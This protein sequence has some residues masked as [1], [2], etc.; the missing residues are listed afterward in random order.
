MLVDT[1]WPAADAGPNQWTPD[2]GSDHKARLGS[3]GGSN[4]VDDGSRYLESAT[5][6]HVDAFTLDPLLADPAAIAAVQARTFHGRRL[7]T[8]RRLRTNLLRGAA[9]HTGAIRAGPCARYRDDREL[10]T[11]DPSTGA[12][13]T[14]AGINAARLRLEVV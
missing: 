4:F 7:G 12:A 8:A 13:W 6:G 10:V 9:Q 1:L 5:S 2:S 11:T 3:D 14:R